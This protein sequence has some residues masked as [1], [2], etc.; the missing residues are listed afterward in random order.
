MKRRNILLVA[1][2]ISLGF[3][4]VSL[5]DG[6]PRLAQQD[7]YKVGFAQ[8]ESNNPWRIAESKSFVDTEIQLTIRDFVDRGYSVVSPSLPTQ[9]S[10]N[11]NWCRLWPKKARLPYDHDH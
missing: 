2:A 9:E 10:Q 6:L 7:S 4:S 3:A 8:M 11:I 5:A 1:T